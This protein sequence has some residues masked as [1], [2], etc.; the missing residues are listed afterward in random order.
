M[1]YT[2]GYQAVVINLLVQSGFI[3]FCLPTANS[4]L[5]SC[6]PRDGSRDGSSGSV[7][8]VILR[9]Q[10]FVNISVNFRRDKPRLLSTV[11]H[12]IP[13]DGKMHFFDNNLK[14]KIYG[15]ELCLSVVKETVLN[16]KGAGES[17]QYSCERVCLGLGNRVNLVTSSSSGGRLWPGRGCCVWKREKFLQ[18]SLMT[19]GPRC[20]KC[21][22]RMCLQD[23]V[24]TTQCPPGDKCFAITLNK[25]RSAPGTNSSILPIM[26]GCSSDDGLQGYSCNDGC[27]REVELVGSGKRR[28]CVRCC[29]GN[30]CNKRE[31]AQD[32]DTVT[33][34]IGDGA[35]DTKV[36]KTV[37]LETNGGSVITNDT[38][39]VA[40]SFIA[41]L[42]LFK[43]KLGFQS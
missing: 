33:A 42:W 22:G 29:T 15:R 2:L 35:R 9:V 43:S 3:W 19:A 38:R 10:R 32:N 20:V 12:T 25:Q 34:V 27:R 36:S 1:A 40:I 39:L 26:L 30:E 8:S 24:T 13:N 41:T 7:T 23:H 4:H 16:E 21:Q 37:E 28:V 18:L 6:Q 17:K 31:G 5:I 14:A 11:H